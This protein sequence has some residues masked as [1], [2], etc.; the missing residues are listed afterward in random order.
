MEH[1]IIVKNDKGFGKVIIIETKPLPLGKV[2]I[3]G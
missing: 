3:K 2:I 1:V